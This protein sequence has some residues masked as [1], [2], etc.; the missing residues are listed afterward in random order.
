MPPGCLSPL[1]QEGCNDQL[2]QQPRRFPATMTDVTPAGHAYTSSWTLR[3]VDGPPEIRATAE[4]TLGSTRV[5]IA[6]RAPAYAAVEVAGKAVAVD[7]EG[8]FSTRV[9]LPPWPTA[10]TVSARDPIGHEASL[11]VS[12]IGIFDYRG[13]PWLPI[14]LGFLAGVAV[15]LIVPLVAE[16]RGD[17]LALAVGDHPG[18]G[19]VFAGAAALL[20]G[21]RAVQHRHVRGR[22]TLA[23]RQLVL[24][25]PPQRRQPAHD[26]MIRL[27]HAHL[28]DVRRPVAGPHPLPAP[29]EPSQATRRQG[30]MTASAPRLLH[31]RPARGLTA[32]Q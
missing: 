3:L 14:A 7:E 18:H 6:G 2:V 12:G 10:V 17:H 8:R 9:D 19:L 26:R 21:K 5:V 31:R 23:V 28:E 24:A 4:T 16:H 32:L 13:L 22:A 30:V 20:A 29:V 15:G 1:S 11:I 25:V 27:A